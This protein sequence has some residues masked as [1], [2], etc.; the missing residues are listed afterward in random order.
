MNPGVK[1]Y[2]LLNQATA[3]TISIVKTSPKKS[4]NGQLVMAHESIVNALI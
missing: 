4:N 2:L 1:D 3:A